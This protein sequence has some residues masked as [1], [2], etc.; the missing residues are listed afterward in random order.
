[1]YHPKRKG[2]SSSPI[3]FQGRAVK[4]WGCIRG[5]SCL[6]VDVSYT[7]KSY[8]SVFWFTEITQCFYHDYLFFVLGIFCMKSFNM[9]QIQPV[10]MKHM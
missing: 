5:G 3:I 8:R 7:F 4:L 6:E 9:N 1:M 2:S 10:L